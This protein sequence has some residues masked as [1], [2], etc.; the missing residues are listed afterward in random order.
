MFKRYSILS[1]GR[2]DG[3]N[4]TTCVSSR[5][6]PSRQRTAKGLEKNLS[7]NILENVLG[8][9][10]ENKLRENKAGKYI[11]FTSLGQV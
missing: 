4:L 6:V 11:M 10:G 9:S 7:D 5:P 2:D 3:T 1:T 8:E